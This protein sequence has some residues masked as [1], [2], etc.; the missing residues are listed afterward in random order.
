MLVV[1]GVKLLHIIIRWVK[2]IYVSRMS[3]GA[4]QEPEPQSKIKGVKRSSSS[5][6]FFK[7]LQV[8]AQPYLISSLI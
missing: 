6:S 4:L 3:Y 1:A 2:V 8:C 7:A 5:H